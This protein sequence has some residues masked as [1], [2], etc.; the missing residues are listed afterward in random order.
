M[1]RIFIHLASLP[2]NKFNTSCLSFR[3]MDRHRSNPGLSEYF[4][5]QHLKPQGK[6]KIEEGGKNQS[7]CSFPESHQSFV[8]SLGLP[9]NVAVVETFLAKR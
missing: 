3:K 4:S 1:R 6:L 2:K 8:V 7:L 9:F 5:I